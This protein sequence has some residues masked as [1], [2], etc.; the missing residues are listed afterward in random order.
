L[1]DYAETVIKENLDLKPD[2]LKCVV[3][4]IAIFVAMA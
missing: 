1:R 4:A 2:S 3:A